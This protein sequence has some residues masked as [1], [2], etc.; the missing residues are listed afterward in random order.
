M[1]Q[2]R[3]FC[4]SM[5]IMS[6]PPQN[7]PEAP[8]PMT[9]QNEH[10]GLKEHFFGRFHRSLSSAVKFT[11]RRRL[12]CNVTVRHK[13]HKSI[14]PKVVLKMQR[15]RFG[16]HFKPLKYFQ[17]FGLISYQI[18]STCRRALPPSFAAFITICKPHSHTHT[19]LRTPPS[20]RTRVQNTCAR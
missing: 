14:H 15:K 8:P 12:L 7:S 3:D 4:D 11:L 9:E 17:R 10:F 13:C 1:T 16:F 2:Y 20:E 5:Y 6:R 19:H 18:G